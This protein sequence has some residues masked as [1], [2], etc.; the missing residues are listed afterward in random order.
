MTWQ[1]HSIS[2]LY[3]SGGTKFMLLESFTKTSISVNRGSHFQV[4]F[5]WQVWTVNYH[6]L[7]I[8]KILKLLEGGKCDRGTTK[9]HARILRG[10]GVQNEETNHV[11][12]GKLKQA[13]LLS[14]QCNVISSI[15]YYKYVPIIYMSYIYHHII[16]SPIY[17]H[18]TITNTS[19]SFFS[20][21][22]ISPCHYTSHVSLYHPYIT[23]I[24]PSFL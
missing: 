20:N 13:Q 5:V 15:Y 10:K 3:P 24:S 9:L 23:H 17:H 8:Y 2:F 1:S 16:V 4:R 21:C 12:C 14:Y 7:L 22:Y 6:P 19:S 18:I 11:H